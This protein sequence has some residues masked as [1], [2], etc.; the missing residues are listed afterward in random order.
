MDALHNHRNS[1]PDSV[2]S[3]PWLPLLAILHTCNFPLRSR[4]RACG[5]LKMV[6]G[7]RFRRKQVLFAF[8]LISAL[9]LLGIL[10][11]PYSMPVRTVLLQPLHNSHVALWYGT[12]S[13]GDRARGEVGI[14]DP[15]QVLNGP[16]TERFRGGY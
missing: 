1:N 9:W 16:P 14:D 15:Q 6:V 10:T 4:Q 3:K 8:L 12:D 5:A 11:W 7:T 13:C 2:S